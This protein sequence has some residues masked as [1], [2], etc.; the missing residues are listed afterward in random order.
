MDFDI[1]IA[2]GGATGLSFILA[3]QHC[4]AKSRQ[5]S[6]DPLKVALVEAWCAGSEQ[7]HPGFDARAIALSQQTLAIFAKL[8]LSD[9]ISATTT[10]IR[11]IHISDQ[12]G[13]GQCTLDH[14]DYQVSELGSVIEAHHLGGCLAGAVERH[15]QPEL[16][17]LTRFQPD[18]IT[19]ITQV[20]ER[21]VA[22]LKSGQQV[23]GKLLIL[24]EGGKSSTRDLLPIS[25]A[26]N[27]YQQSAIIANIVTQKPHQNTA[28]ERFTAQ[29]PLAFLPMSDNRSGV[30]WSV[31]SA[32]VA[33]LMAM[34]EQ[35]FIAQLQKIFGYRLGT[36]TKA[37]K[38]ASFPLV[39]VNADDRFAHRTVCIGNAAQTLHPIAGQGF[40]LAIRDAWCLAVNVVD[41]LCQGHDIGSYNRLKAFRY[42]RQQD[43][44]NTLLLTDGLVRLF[45]NK[46]PILQAS[47]NLGLMAMQLNDF[48]KTTFANIAMGKKAALPDPQIASSRSAMQND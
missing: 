42:L 7:Q 16:I 39:L 33:S 46:D 18:H 47:R 24:A 28:F 37:G 5:A 1:V 10:A 14:S 15:V 6:G 29:G 45:S 20:K 9:T 30:V 25:V 13:A 2:G 44:E 32:E 3:L 11:H 12:G 26:N 19:A 43:K 35:Q 41:G 40:N 36:I 22:T 8:Q 31:S 17:S 34:T 48:S 38:R 23:T 4:L 21:T 27:D